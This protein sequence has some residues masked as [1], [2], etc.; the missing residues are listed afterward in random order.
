MQTHDIEDILTSVEASPA[1]RVARDN[2]NTA[3]RKLR[4]SAPAGFDAA[5]LNLDTLAGALV[6]EALIATPR[7]RKARRDYTAAVKEIGLKLPA[8]RQWDLLELDDLAGT[9][10]STARQAA[11]LEVSHDYDL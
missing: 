2:Y 7:K 1:F 3:L 6:T 11:A 5:L 10:V 9:M 8:A 4:A